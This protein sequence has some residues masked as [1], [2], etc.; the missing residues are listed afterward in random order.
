MQGMEH[1]EVSPAAEGAFIPFETTFVITNTRMPGVDGKIHGS[2]KRSLVIWARR[3]ARRLPDLGRIRISLV[4]VNTQ[5]KRARRAGRLAAIAAALS[6][7]LYVA[8]VVQERENIIGTALAVEHRDDPIGDHLELTVT[9]VGPAVGED[10]ECGSCGEPGTVGG[11]CAASP[12]E[13]G[14]HRNR[15]W[16]H[17]WCGWCGKDF[18]G[19]EP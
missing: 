16:E 8:G 9:R 7:G 6:S 17:A 13:C 2:T 1:D 4:W 15:S 5:D 14:H 18:G 11:E 3:A 19:S 10:A 12:R